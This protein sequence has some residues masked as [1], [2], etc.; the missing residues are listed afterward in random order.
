MRGVL[1]AALLLATPAVAKERV[2]LIKA[3]ETP[4]GVVFEGG[5]Y[6]GISGIDHD[7]RSGLWAF[8]S[9]DKSEHGPSH[10]FLGRLDVRPTKP[11]G[12]TLEKMIPLRR[13]DG[14][15]FP[16]RKA[17]TEAADGESV[18]F[19]PQ[20]REEERQDL[21]WSTEGDFDHGYPPAVRRMKADG[22]PVARIVVPDALTFHAGGRTGARKNATTEGLAWSVDGRSLWLSME[23]PLVQDGPIPSVAEGGLVRL[24]RLDR[25]GKPLAQYAYRI[26]PV[27]AASPVG[28]GDNGVSEILALDDHRLLVLERSGIKGADGRYGYHV[29]LY[30]ADLA[31]AQS[32]SKV[33]S[34]AATSVRPAEKRL[35]LNFDSLGIR[36]DNLE[37]MAWG[38]RLKDGTRT[39]VLAS[40]D[41]YDA[42]QTNQI[43]V[44]R[45]ER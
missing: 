34:L 10:I 11:C 1:F 35:L 43:L 15:T 3:C 9:D 26:D 18:R 42:N 36:I 24:T 27:Q 25:A 21:V 30:L 37:A 22:T 32:I 39:L 14:A 17:G 41:N 13:E 23:G 31:K 19:D 38:P 7:P 12:P 33:E 44:L 4:K 2:S 20:I 6:G 8:I 45:F 28:V 16:D 29:R 40:D 5:G